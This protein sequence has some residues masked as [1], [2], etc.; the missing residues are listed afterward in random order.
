MEVFIL[1]IILVI[2]FT[3]VDL[4]TNGSDKQYNSRCRSIS[5]EVPIKH[6]AEPPNRKQ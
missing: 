5:R 6:E 4:L 3:F 1:L 2:V